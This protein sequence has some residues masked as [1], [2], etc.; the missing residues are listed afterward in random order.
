MPAQTTENGYVSFPDGAR[1]L[2]KKSGGSYRDMGVL[3]SPINLS[4]TYTENI[5]EFANAARVKQIK[6]MLVDGSFT[7]ANL[8]PYNYEELSG[9]AIS[10]EVQTGSAITTFDNQTI[11]G[12]TA[13]VTQELVAVETAT[14]DEIKFSTT[15]VITSI[16]GTTTMVLTADDYIIVK[17]S[18]LPSGY[19][20]QFNT[21]NTVSTETFTIVYG[22]NTPLTGTTLYAGTSALEVTAYSIKFSH[23]NGSGVVDRE[24]ELYSADTTSG[25]IQFNFKGSNEDGVDESPV[26]FQGKIDTS[27]DDG[28]QLF[29]YYV[30]A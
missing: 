21:V 25:G 28:K 11:V 13:G 22:T 5:V 17:D 16:T 24:L 7:L 23:Y 1:V 6:Q 2:I 9:G 26:T 4:M 14:G 18:N 30:S 27:R 29:R 15:P 20:I 12:Y 10:R 19:G 3:T 8:D